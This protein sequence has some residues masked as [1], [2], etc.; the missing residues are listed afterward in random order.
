MILFTIC[1]LFIMNVYDGDGR[2]NPEIYTQINRFLPVFVSEPTFMQQK[3]AYNV[4]LVSTYSAH[5]YS[6]FSWPSSTSNLR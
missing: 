6:T 1:D 4:D 5:Y 2:K 3:F